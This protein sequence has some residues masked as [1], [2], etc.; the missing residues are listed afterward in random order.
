[1]DSGNV[2]EPHF[3]PPSPAAGRPTTQQIQEHLEE[4]E[5]LLKALKDNIDAGRLGN[6]QGYQQRL[7]ASLMWLAAVADAQTQAPAGGR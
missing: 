4:N 1:M 2:E 5:R 7:Q 6:T 3:V